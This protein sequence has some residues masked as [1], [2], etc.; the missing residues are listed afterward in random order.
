VEASELAFGAI[1]VP[2]LVGLACYFGWR[3][4]R[5][6]RELSR[7]PELSREDRLYVRGQ[8]VRRLACSALMLSLAGLLVGSYFLEAPLQHVREER[9]EQTAKGTAEEVQ[10]EHRA[11]LQHFAAY[12]IMILLVLMILVLLVAVDVWAIARFGQRQHRQLRAD[13]QATLASEVARLRQRYNGQQ[14]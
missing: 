3:Q 2:V 9:A 14:H 10:P 8:A 5:T 13:L 11:F 1:L 4:V 7:Q 6:L 12:W